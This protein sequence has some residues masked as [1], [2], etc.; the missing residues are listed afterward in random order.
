MGN[1]G[2]G[3]EWVICRPKREQSPSW[4]GRSQSCSTC[5]ETIHSVKPPSLQCFVT[6]APGQT[7]RLRRV[8]LLVQGLLGVGPPVTTQ[9]SPRRLLAFEVLLVKPS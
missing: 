9:V 4:P 7:K 3:R 1:T 6:A 8:E 2:V 5:T